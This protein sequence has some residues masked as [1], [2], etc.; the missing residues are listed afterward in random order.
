MMYYLCDGFIRRVT[1][2]CSLVSQDAFPGVKMVRFG[3][4]WNKQRRDLAIRKGKRKG[5]GTIVTPIEGLL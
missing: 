5:E 4:S 3:A 2:V 1:S